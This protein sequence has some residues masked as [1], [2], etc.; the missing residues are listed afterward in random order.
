MKRL[1]IV[2]AGGTGED[3]VE[4]V[5]AINRQRSA[6][7][8]IGFLDDDPGKQGRTIL[9]LPVLGPLSSATEHDNT[10][11]V[12]CLGSPSNFRNRE[13]LIGDIGIADDR[14]ETLI[15]PAAEVSGASSIGTGSVIYPFV[16]VGPSANIGRHVIVLSQ[17]SVNHHSTVGD[18]SILTT[19]CI[20]SGH[21][22]IRQGLFDPKDAV[23]FKFIRHLQDVVQLL[24]SV[25]V[26]HQVNVIDRFIY[27]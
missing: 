19:G 17:A 24:S 4:I 9:S 6:Y 2:G 3:A 20:V 1:V 23:L 21:V 26:N 7:E 8:P 11:F 15:H 12:D 13:A 25:E 27:L 16:Y 22:V 14:F 10:W 5:K 18:Y